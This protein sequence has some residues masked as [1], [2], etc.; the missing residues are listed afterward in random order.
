ML[1]SLARFSQPELLQDTLERALTDD[2]R[3]QDS[4]T[5]ISSVAGNIRGRQPAWDFVKDNWA[6]LDRRYGGG[7]FGI[8]RLVS[9]TNNF[10]EMEKLADVETFFQEHPAPAAERTIR[11]ALERIQLNATWVEKNDSELSTWFSK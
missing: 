6:E 8:M 7:G 9:I 3:S 4:I 10:A 1:I 11:Q 5:V 2:V